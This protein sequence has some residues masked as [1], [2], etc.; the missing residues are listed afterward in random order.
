MVESIDKVNMEV[1]MDLSM[2]GKLLYLKFND[3]NKDDN[4]SGHIHNIFLNYIFIV[5][6]IKKHL[7]YYK[8]VIKKVSEIS[9]NMDKYMKGSRV[10]LKKHDSM[11]LLKEQEQEIE[12]YFDELMNIS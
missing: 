1:L 11:F 9:D 4:I 2:K 8:N 3:I 6:L 12:K 10:K 5:N 7:I